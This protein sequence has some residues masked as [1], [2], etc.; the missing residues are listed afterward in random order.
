MNSDDYE[1]L[2]NPDSHMNLLANMNADNEQFKWIW[3]YMYRGIYLANLTIQNIE[4]S[5]IPQ[6]NKDQFIAECK[7]LRGVYFWTLTTYWGSVPI[8]TRPLSAQEYFTQKKN[9]KEECWTQTEQD[10][11]WAA[12]FLP[13]SY[14]DGEVGRVTK[15]GALA[16]LAKTYMQEKKFTDAEPILAMIVNSGTYSLIPDYGK[17]WRKEGEQLTE[18]VWEVNHGYQP[19]IVINH[20]E[21]PQ[22]SF[23]AW[24]M[25]PNSA[26]GAAWGTMTEDLKQEFEP[27]DP[28]IIYTLLFDG[29]KWYTDITGTLKTH[30]SK[31]GY[32]AASYSRFG[33]PYQ[34]RKYAKRLNER[35][36]QLEN[37]GTFG[38]P[39]NYKFIRYSDV[40]LLYAEALNENGKSVQAVPYVNEVRTRANTTPKID[41]LRILQIHTVEPEQIPMLS[42]S[43]NQTD[44]RNKIRHERRVEL[45]GEQWRYTDMLRWGIAGETMKAYS[46]KYPSHNKGTYWKDYFVE[47]PVPASEISLTNGS[48]V[49][50]P[51]Y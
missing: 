33:D 12:K 18:S 41:P 8:I 36:G 46:Q 13:S 19:G 1:N 30:D 22:G 3:N 49:Q 28:R 5:S 17:V 15:G 14:P 10:F 27:G 47:Y 16:M 38:D 2:V 31:V 51:N 20:E 44:L 45:A 11:I 25:Q 23:F 6:S 35:L 4:S 48:I 40:L 26:D 21:G 7:A 24:A 43:L 37:N 34:N 42:L 32:S 9:T 29:D 50:N 39:L